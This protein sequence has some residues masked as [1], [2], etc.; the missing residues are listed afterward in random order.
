LPHGTLFGPERKLVPR[1][2]AR[3]ELFKNSHDE[4]REQGVYKTDQIKMR[5]LG[6][7]GRDGVF[8]CFLSSPVNGQIG[9]IY[10]HI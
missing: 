9:Y 3:D 8:V 2:Q 10:I 5:I 4:N 1:R 7:F 6:E